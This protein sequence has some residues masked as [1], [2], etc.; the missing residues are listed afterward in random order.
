M[1][2]NWRHWKAEMQKRIFQSLSPDFKKGFSQSWPWEKYGLISWRA[3]ACL[4][5]WAS[6]EAYWSIPLPPSL[7]CV[8]ERLGLVLKKRNSKNSAKDSAANCT[9]SFV[10]PT[11][12]VLLGRIKSRKRMG[13]QNSLNSIEENHHK[14][15]EFKR[16][17]E[18]SE[19]G[20]PRKLQIGRSE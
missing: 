11:T 20:I 19:A 15:V 14:K 1:R 9:F 12:A 7:P 8:L 2:K 18:R 4:Q 10:R 13:F 17:R 5:W 3:V 6:F 16:P